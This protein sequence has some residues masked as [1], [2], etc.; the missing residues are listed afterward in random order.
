[1]VDKQQLP[2]FMSDG[3]VH[4]TRQATLKDAIGPF[5]RHLRSEG[6]TLNTIKGFTSDMHLMCQFL[7][8]ERLLLSIRTVDLNRFLEWLEHGR[9]QV[10]SRKSY[11]RRVTTLKVFFK[12][13]EQ[14]HIR[15]DNPAKTLIQRSGPAPLQTIIT[16]YEVETLM[17]YSN[18]LRH[19]SKPDSRPALLIR[20]LLDTGI[21]KSE[22]M[23]LAFEHVQKNFPHQPMLVVR[24]K[25]RHNQ[26]KDRHIGLDMQWPI[27]LE[28]Y[29]RQYKVNQVIFP[30]T[31]RNLEYVLHDTAT[32]A[33]IQSRVSFEILRWTCAVRD[34]L[35]GMD[36]EALREK[37][38]LSRISWRET[39]EKILKIADQQRARL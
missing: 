20:L 15:A 21:K 14:T 31:P 29:R 2:L 22:C 27:I 33:G 34:Y 35:N 11:A 24:H 32:A 39:S 23:E 6:K 8:E 30:C 7:G 5:Q 18:Q 1:M 37:M 16:P 25:D 38:G 3:H 36:M 4:L 17:A 19:A 28:E 12:W 9:G 10:C 13:L 26:Y